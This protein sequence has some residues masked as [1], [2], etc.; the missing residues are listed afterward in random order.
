M[1]TLSLRSISTMLVLV[2][3]LVGGIGLA[4]RPAGAEDHREAPLR[5]L[6]INLDMTDFY[7]FVDPDGTITTPGTLT[8]VPF[9]PAN[10]NDADADLLFNQD[11]IPGSGSTTF[12]V[13]LIFMHL[14]S[15][16]PLEVAFPDGHTTQYDLDVTTSLTTPSQGTMQLVETSPDGGSFFTELDIY[17]QLTF[18]DRATGAT[19]VVDGDTENLVMQVEASGSYSYACP[20]EHLRIPGVTADFCLGHF[21]GATTVFP[22]TF[23]DRNNPNN[24]ILDWQVHPAS[25]PS[26]RP[27]VIDLIADQSVNE[28]ELLT[29]SVHTNDPDDDTVSLDAANL[30]PGASFIDDGDGSGSFDF[31]PDFNQAGTYEVAITA[32]DDGSPSL[33]D[34]TTFTI[35]VNNVNRPPEI[36]VIN[37]IIVDE[38]ATDEFVEITSTDPDGDA[39]SLTLVSGPDFL[40]LID[41]GDGTAIGLLTPDGDDAGIYTATVEATDDGTP[42][43]NALQEFTITVIDINQPP[44][45]EPISDVDIDEGEAVTGPINASDPDGDGMTFQFE[46]PD[47]CVIGDD[48]DGNGTWQCAPDHDDGGTYTVTV[49]VIDDGELSRSDSVTFTV[50]VHNVN[51]APLLDPIGD[52]TIDAGEDGTIELRASDPDDDKLTFTIVE[53]PSFCNLTDNGDGTGTLKCEPGLDDTG[54]HPVKVRA[55]D[56]GNPNLFVEEP[57][58][59]TVPGGREADVELVEK[60]DDRDPVL[61]GTPL[62]YTVTIRNNGPVA[63]AIEFT[64]AFLRTGVSSVKAFSEQGR[65]FTVA[66]LAGFHVS[67]TF[68]ALKAGDTVKVTI[69]VVPRV[70]G[71]LR[72]VSAAVDG[73]DHDPNPGNNDN[74]DRPTSTNVVNVDVY[75]NAVVGGK[76]A[77]LQGN[78]SDELNDGQAKALFATLRTARDAFEKEDYKAARQQIEAFRMQIDTVGGHLPKEQREALKAEADLM[79]ESMDFQG[80]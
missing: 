75:I 2:L 28:G 33:S 10:F 11:I 60:I 39:L 53:G 59:L 15:I 35:I 6:A 25:A 13:E 44:I 12:G 56:D 52:Q 1:R 32:S 23:I 78:G 20:A 73:V 72:N 42:P 19:T 55:T 38:F 65:C 71:T 48:G 41:H 45:L 5:T 68:G 36:P 57:F 70:A 47:F 22:T 51:Q 27:P 4:M 54:D 16:Q 26:N 8:G 29:V 18:T 40:S 77:A 31:A 66:D 17:L 62:T 21:P 49:T 67:C 69:E 50:T 79:L 9:D 30:P 80:L 74:E 24:P 61:V 76:V 3:A 37:E 14:R 58:N 46:G 64:D 34:E 7:A 63:T 43:L